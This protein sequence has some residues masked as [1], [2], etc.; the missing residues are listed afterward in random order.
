MAESFYGRSSLSQ[1][2]QRM[3]FVPLAAV[4][5]AAVVAASNALG[6][7]TRTI[8]VLWYSYAHPESTYRK[9][10]ER[11]GAV[12]HTIPQSSGTK[13]RITFYGPRDA[14]PAFGRYDVLVIQSGEGFGS[15][16]PLLPTLNKVDFSGILQFKAAITAARG[17]RTVLTGADADVHAIGGE[18]GHAPVKEGY[19]LSCDPPF[20]G[21]RCW[22]GAAGH[23]INAV[24]WAA[25]GTKMGIV[26]LVA[27]EFPG[28]DWWLHPDSFLREEL[29]AG[30][31]LQSPIRVL[32]PGTREN[33]P[34]I[35]QEAL[36]HPLNAGLTS[37]GLGN[38]NNSFHATFAQPL[39][40]YVAIV[41]STRYPGM[42]VVIA[43][44]KQSTLK[45]PPATGTRK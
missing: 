42:A 10:I 26:S 9:M 33:T 38:W 23:L 31:T 45:P 28:S 39:P 37:K 8:S 24:N 13:W 5:L 32:G 7:E 17:S 36:H 11:L 2:L 27:A 22:D 35:P 19:R 6:A 29:T 12:V 40:G 21:Q 43:S 30:R 20:T 4:S 3:L 16:H 1:F 25:G 18:T 41:N 15:G 34:V 14:R 44:D